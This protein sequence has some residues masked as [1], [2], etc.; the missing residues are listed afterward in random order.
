MKHEIQDTTILDTSC[1]ADQLDRYINLDLL[2]G[3]DKNHVDVRHPV[4]DRMKLHR[5][6][7]AARG[8]AIEV[9]THGVRLIGVDQ[10]TKIELLHVEGDARLTVAIDYAGDPAFCAK[11]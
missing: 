3:V 9:E 2:A 4:R 5:T 7:E 6:K 1:G 11:L 10:R 8:R